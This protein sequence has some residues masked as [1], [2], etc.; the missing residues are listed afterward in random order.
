[1][2]RKQLILPLLALALTGCI[3]QSRIQARY[4]EAQDDCRTQ[5]EQRVPAADTTTNANGAPADLSGALARQFSDCMNKAG[6]HVAT[7]K[8]NAP[9][10][11]AMPTSAPGVPAPVPVPPP[12]AHPVP[13]VVN[14]AAPAAPILGPGVQPMPAVAVPPPSARTA[15]PL[16][17]L[18][19]SNVPPQAPA[20][21]QPGRPGDAGDDSSYGAGAGRQF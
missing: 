19:P 11:Q 6:W 18:P 2:Q 5:A 7:P 15:A 8:V 12:S 1:M 3:A 4:M 16:T 10:P 14:G 20:T 21:Y 13:A 17:A 9:A